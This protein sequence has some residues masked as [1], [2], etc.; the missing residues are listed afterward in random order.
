MP[1][2]SPNVAAKEHLME[3]CRIPGVAFIDINTRGGCLK[4][5]THNTLETR[6]AHIDNGL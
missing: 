4:L 5:L 1:D 6:V 2:G 3:Q